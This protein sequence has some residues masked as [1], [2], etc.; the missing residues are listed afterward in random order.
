M[1]GDVLIPSRMTVTFTLRR[2]TDSQL[3]ATHTIEITFDMPAT[4]PHIVVANVTGVLMNAAQRTHGEPL[5]GRL[6][7]AAPNHFVFGLSAFPSDAERNGALLRDR[8]RFDIPI[9]Y[10]DGH[11][12]MLAINK[13]TAGERIL[14]DAIA[15]WQKA[16]AADA[17]GTNAGAA[18]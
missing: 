13:G 6:I 11:R 8:R 4:A 1:R 18:K 2:N 7:T 12:A 16:G 9:V 5:T 14:N 10:Q 15:A 3:P 17:N